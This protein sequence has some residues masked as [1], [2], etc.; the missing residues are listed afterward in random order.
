MS[1]PAFLRRR[2]RVVWRPPP[3]QPLVPDELRRASPDLEAEFATLERELVPTFTALDRDAMRAQNAFRLGQLVLILGGLTATV[4]GAVQAALGGGVLWV[5]L[6][7][8]VVA[9]ALGAAVVYLQL[10]HTQRE[11]LT[12]R[13]K[14]ERLRG[15]YFQFLG[16]LAPYDEGDDTARAARLRRRVSEVDLEEVPA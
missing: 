10:G 8:A 11:Y 6:V 15:E 7:Q 9:G 14:A 4:L 16:R 1:V 12:K 5:G 3:P 2:P 13:V